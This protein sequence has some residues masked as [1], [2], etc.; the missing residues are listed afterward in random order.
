M[1][2]ITVRKEEFPEDRIQ[3]MDVTID[4]CSR[5]CPR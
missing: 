1:A 5:R 2:N 4:S 3:Y